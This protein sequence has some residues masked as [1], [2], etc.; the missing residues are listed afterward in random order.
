MSD[1]FYRAIPAVL[2]HEGGYVNNPADPGGETNFGI[3]KRN[4]PAL[5]I[6]NLAVG[7]AIDIYQKDY[8]KHYMDKIASYPVAAKLFDMS[9]NMGHKQANKLLQRA[10]GIT[11]DGIFGPATLWAVNEY[12]GDL[13]QQMVDEQI[14]FYADLA[15]SKPSMSQF[16]KGWMSRARWVPEG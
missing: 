3:C 9:V 7:D 2:K 4:Y 1:Y 12:T 16:L 14:H 13:V 6:K 10:L 15:A 5:D 11:A 8:W